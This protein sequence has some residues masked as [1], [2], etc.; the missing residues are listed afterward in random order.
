[1][2]GFQA[3]FFQQLLNNPV[4]TENIEETSGPHRE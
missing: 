1:M 4:A 3:A 2:I